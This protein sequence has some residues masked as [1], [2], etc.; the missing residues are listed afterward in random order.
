MLETLSA[1]LSAYGWDKLLELGLFLVVAA[2]D[3]ATKEGVDPAVF[4]ARVKTLERGRE[5]AI[6]AMRAKWGGLLP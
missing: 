3:M 4:D 1:W 6:A 5:D 2:K